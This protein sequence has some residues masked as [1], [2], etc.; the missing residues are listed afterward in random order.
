[1]AFTY[2]K[3]KSA[4]CLCLL[5][6]VLVFLIS[7][8]VLRI[9]SCLHHCHTRYSWWGLLLPPQE[10]HP[11]FVLRPPFSALRAS[12][13]SLFQQSSF[14]P[15]HRG[16]DKTLVVPIFGA[17]ECIRTQDFAL[18]IYK[19]SG[20]TG[21]PAAVR[22]KFCS[23]PPP[24][25]P[26]TCWCPSASSSLATA[27]HGGVLPPLMTASGWKQSFVEVSVP[28]RFL[29]SAS[30]SFVRANGSGGRPFV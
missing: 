2:L 10:P 9:W 8:L 1:M 18:K 16:L 28:F 14:P 7:V 19:N 22:D 27:L 20:G 12:I 3:V 23:H 21:T 29:L 6:V 26:A 25:P 5:S 24:C 15:M 4:K 11:A 30:V 17:K 13:G